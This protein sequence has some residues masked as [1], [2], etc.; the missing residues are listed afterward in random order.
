MRKLRIGFI[1]V[2]P[3]LFWDSGEDLSPGPELNLITIP[4]SKMGQFID[5]L[6]DEVLSIEQQLLNEVKSE[7]GE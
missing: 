4:L 5:S 2:Q 3:V 6:P 1:K 7:V